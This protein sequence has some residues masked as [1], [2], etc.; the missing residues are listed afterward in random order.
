MDALQCV[1]IV[2]NSCNFWPLGISLAIICE[3]DNNHHNYFNHYKPHTEYIATVNQ[4]KLRASMGINGNRI[5][6]EFPLSYRR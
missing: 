3:H 5:F 2:G 6:F 1:E 4:K